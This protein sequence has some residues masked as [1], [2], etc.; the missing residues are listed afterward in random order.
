[1]RE[2]LLVV[3]LLIF[4][5][6][7]APVFHGP[8]PVR[9]QHPAQLS[10]LHMDPASAAPLALAEGRVHV[11]TGYSSYFVAGKGGGNSFQMD[12]EL[13]RTGIKGG[14]G[15][16]HGLGL[17]LELAFAHATGGFLDSFLIEYHEFFGFPD[18]N[19]PSFP[20]NQF[21]V[22]ATRGGTTVYE[23]RESTLEQ[24]DTPLELRW[25]FLPITER[26][27]FGAC[28]RAAVELP[29]GDQHS[30]FGNGGV[31]YSFGVLG[32]LRRESYAL[33]AH[34]QHTFVVTP[35]LARAGGF[36]YGD[37]TSCGL[38]GEF[39]VSDSWALLA[40]TEFETST[41]R[42]LGFSE[43]AGSQWMLWGGIRALVAPRV[44]LD[45]GFGE[46]LT[47]DLAPD[48]T[49]YVGLTFGIGGAAP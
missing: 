44:T 34:A 16:G 45:I 31:D 37:V 33:T 22:N 39:W 47:T 42:D 48:F 18:Q 2:L 8:M 12:G 32:E 19:R 5:C 43:V 10:V 17:Y 35:D 38:G 49:A 20:R 21:E 41:L 6:A 27:S 3:P 9:N 24:L 7:T 1:M 23:M 13:A 36:E 40:Q 46:D 14:I 30:G 4:G 29:T 25:A 28:V 26:E 15:L 11:D